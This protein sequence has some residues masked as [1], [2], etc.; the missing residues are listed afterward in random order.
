M[1]RKE[2][3]RERERES[4][5]EHT[6][7]RTLTVAHCTCVIAPWGNHE[8]EARLVILDK[9]A[10]RH[11]STLYPPTF[12]STHVF[13]HPSLFTLSRVCFLGSPSRRMPRHYVHEAGQLRLWLWVRSGNRPPHDSST[14]DAVSCI[15][16][17][18]P[19]LD[20]I[21]RL[22]PLRGILPHF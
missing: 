1:N 5:I 9:C 18:R 8:R 21:S 6:Q 20:T 14:T 22:V 13:L 16:A 2:R 7:H 11:R 19:D 4:T 10:S 12:T 15:L 17:D 3:E